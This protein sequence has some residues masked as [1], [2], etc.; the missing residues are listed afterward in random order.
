MTFTWFLSQ[1]KPV[2]AW[3]LN[4]QQLSLW[5]FLVG[6]RPVCI[7]RMQRWLH[8]QTTRPYHTPHQPTDPCPDHFT[9]QFWSEVHLGLLG[10]SGRVRGRCQEEGEESVVIQE[11]E[12]EVKLPETAISALVTNLDL[13]WGVFHCIAAYSSVYITSQNMP[14]KARPKLIFFSCNF[15]PIKVFENKNG[16]YIKRYPWNDISYFIDFWNFR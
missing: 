6:V 2:K 16:Y 11:G 5:D 9:R 4:C 15:W 13:E 8:H 10:G 3:Q 7:G 1:P 14:T 12:F